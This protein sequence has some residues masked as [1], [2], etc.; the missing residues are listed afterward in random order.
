MGHIWCYSWGHVSYCFARSWTCFRI[1]NSAG[2]PL[3]DTFCF[4][5]DTLGF[6][7]SALADAWP[8][9]YLGV[10]TLSDPLGCPS[11]EW[12]SAMILPAACG[13]GHKKMQIWGPNGLLMYSLFF[14][15]APIDESPIYYRTTTTASINHLS[16]TWHISYNIISH[17]TTFEVRIFTWV[18]YSTW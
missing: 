3:P 4:L 11:T 5:F 18:K 14:Y 9:R 2:G 13:C 17:I 10:E 1:W 8:V 12:G 6:E 7:V 16:W 15:Q